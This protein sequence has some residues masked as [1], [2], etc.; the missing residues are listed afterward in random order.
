MVSVGAD[1]IQLAADHLRI[2][3]YMAGNDRRRQ[4]A[5]TTRMSMDMAHGITMHGWS[6]DCPCP[7]ASSALNRS[8]P[9]PTDA[10]LP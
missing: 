8:S 2:L 9:P 10:E 7:S 1:G 4:N 6:D 5:L 3:A